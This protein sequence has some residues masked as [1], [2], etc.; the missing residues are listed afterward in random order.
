MPSSQ[1]A[2][3][4]ANEHMRVWGGRGACVQVYAPY[5][6]VCVHERV[7]E[8]STAIGSF[9]SSGL[10]SSVLMCICHDESFM[11][12]S[13]IKLFICTALS[14]GDTAKHGGVR[15]RRKR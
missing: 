3:I 15:L 12:M 11:K 6:V 5:K 2:S 1:Q 13:R 14:I 9:F 7:E 4:I 10:L 8:R